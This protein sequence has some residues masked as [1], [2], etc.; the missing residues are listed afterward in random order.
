MNIHQCFLRV[1]LHQCFRSDLADL[2]L[3]YYPQVQSA[4]LLLWSPEGRYALWLPCSR[5]VQVD[6][7]SQLLRCSQ[8]DLSSPWRQYFQVDQFD[9]LRL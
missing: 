3:R 1:L 2:W 9:L 8:R 6:Q 4:P 7:L 5:L